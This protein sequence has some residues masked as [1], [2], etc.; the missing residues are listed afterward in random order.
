MLKRKMTKNENTKQDKEKPNLFKKVSQAFYWFTLLV[1]LIVSILMLLPVLSLPGNYKAFSV[2]SGSMFP[3]IKIGDMV[4][5]REFDHY[6]EGDI[7]TFY[8]RDDTLPTTHRIVE[9]L[10]DNGVIKLKTQG[11][12]NEDPDLGYRYE[13]AVTG[14]VLLSIPLLGFVV[15]FARTQLGFMLLILLPATFIIYSELNVVKKEVADFLKSE[16]YKEVKKKISNVLSRNKRT[17]EVSNSEPVV[18]EKSE[19]KVKKSTKKRN[20]KRKKEK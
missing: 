5:T 12:Q 7:I 18:E 4:L 15:N 13:N 19:K 20:T 11:D 2:T 14:K 17:I 6:Q 9:R 16:K 8:L 1:V 10:N 3:A